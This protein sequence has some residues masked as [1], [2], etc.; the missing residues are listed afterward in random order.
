MRR[1]DPF[2]RPFFNRVLR[3]PI[4]A[5]VQAFINWGRPNQGLAL[6]EEKL[7]PGEKEALAS[8][9][10]DMG[11][12]MRAM[13]K[14]GTFLRVGNTKTHG[15]VR[16][17]VIIRDD[18]PAHIRHGIFAEP[19]TYKSWV[20]FSGPGPDSPAD[21]DDVGFGSI[22]IKMMGVPGEKLLGDEK[23]TQDLICV[24]TPTF[25]T[26]D[27][28][29]NAK[30]QVQSN[31]RGTPFMYFWRPGATHILD[32]LMQGLWNETKTSPLESQYWSCVPYL[33]GEGQAMV[34]S[35]RPKVWTRSRVPNL[36]LRPPDNYLRDALLDT[37]AVREA[38]F[39]ILVQVQTDPHK[40]PLENAGVRWPEKLSPWVPVAT[41]RLPMQ[42]PSWP[43]QLDLANRLSYNPWHCIKEHRPLGNQSRARFD[44]YHTLSLLR[45]TENRTPHIEPTGEEVLEETFDDP[46]RDDGAAW[47]DQGGVTIYAPV[48]P[49]SINALKQE[50]AAIQSRVQ[51][52]GMPFARSRRIH[53]ARF[54]FVEEQIDAGLG[55]CGPA[56]AYQGDFDGPL[57]RHLHE[58]ADIAAGELVRIGHFLVDPIPADIA[59][60]RQW[61]QDHI[62]P[63]ATLYVNAIGRTVRQIRSEARL[64]EKIEDFLDRTKPPAHDAQTLRRHIVDFVRG[65]PSLQWAL[66]PVD[67][68]WWRVRR[69]IGRIALLVIGI[70]LAIILS[71]LLILWA[72]AIR[73]HEK[74]EYGDPPIPEPAHVTE[75]ANAEDRTLQN[76]FSALGF[77]KAT[78][79]RMISPVI[80]LWLAKIVV[81]YFF[82]T[83]NL[84]NLKTIHFAHWTFIDRKRRMLFTSNYD[85][86]HE[87]YMGDFIDIVGWGLNASFSHGV[88]YPRTRWLILDG[89]WN[90]RTFK[91]HNRNRQITTQVWYA[92][93]P[94]LSAVNIA[95]NAKLRASLSAPQNDKQSIDWLKL[96]RRDWGRPS[97]EP[98]VLEREDM[99][100]LVTRGHSHH[101]AACFFLLTF[102]NGEDGVAA[103]KRWLSGLIADR[104]VVMN[105]KREDPC[106]HLA[107]TLE[108]LR[109]FG[110]AESLLAG[111][112]DEFRF[113]M[114]AEHR[115]RLLGD[116]GAS[117]PDKWEW[118]RTDQTMH[119]VLML[120]TADSDQLTRVRSRYET[121]FRQHGISAVPRETTWLANKKE[122]FGFHDGI[123]TPVIEGIKP[124][125]ETN[126][127]I[128]PGE[129]I[130]GYQNEYHRYPTSPLIHRALDPLSHL[131]LDVEGSGMADFGRNGSYLVFRQL[132]QDVFGF[133]SFIE[134]AARE[135][136]GTSQKRDWLAAKMVGRWRSGAPLVLSPDADDAS[137]QDADNFMFHKADQL[138]LRCPIG[139]H[140]RRTNP[141]DSLDPQ[142]G[143][144]ES[145]SLSKLHRLL[146]RGRTYGQ[147][148]ANMDPEAILAGGDDQ[149]DRGLH[150]IC[151][152]ANI[153]RQFEFVQSSWTNNPQFGALYDDVDPL[154]GERGRFAT[155]NGAPGTG[156]FTIPQAGGRVR[157]RGMPNFVTVRGGAYFFMPGM[158]ALRYLASLP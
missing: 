54:V 109:H 50:L 123:T 45:Q 105:G 117:A 8:I 136:D 142:P 87:N 94:N 39:D 154:I 125:S 22:A 52:D 23:Y 91:R 158:S 68:F 60:R 116:T 55:H 141:R 92:A 73:W 40:M 97:A 139:S 134:K 81:R 152:N 95:E 49:D 82:D 80:F 149:A 102:A 151:L 122:H 29:E 57:K 34:Y 148:L 130:F 75:L 33:L 16:G 65:E 47:E 61:L 38:E 124:D 108:G 43:A 11:N 25:V 147:A 7:M 78:W 133:W 113:G 104:E 59:G 156:N 128:K 88:E 120:Y 145:L 84:A 48:R 4:A 3:E 129:F 111:F 30:L 150:F 10:R 42:A 58:L 9:I 131:K 83:N 41:L 36:P 114:T 14:P 112:S 115:Q 6:A 99:Q 103:A 79:L 27:I 2:Y 56:L 85:G 46:A 106:A 146:R 76:Q 12:Y 93:Y 96:L 21:I 26:P 20:R 121:S 19:K 28:V 138:G 63:D 70:P 110:C 15:V 100:S 24:S 37:L 62:I 119:A 18:I 86:S 31:L 127:S 32:F 135:L 72:L 90:E 153:S 118:G 44:M 74:V 77:R 71:P 1:F 101:K 5:V 64:R 132:R 53:Y 126:L 140:I 13:Y 143:T 144:A 157:V 98:L 155:S 67:D 89:A 137:L 107:F 66:K 51:A 17:E 35:V 69:T